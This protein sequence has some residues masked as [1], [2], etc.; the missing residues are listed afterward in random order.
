[1]VKIVVK[2]K[3]DG[4]ILTLSFVFIFLFLWI[5]MGFNLTNP[6][7]AYYEN[8]FTRAQDGI[9]YFAVESGFWY[10]IKL[11]VKFGIDYQLFLKIYS[12][13]G[14]LLISNS[15]LRYTKRPSLVLVAYFCYPFLLDVAQIRHF[16][17]VAIFTFAIRY[18]EKYSIK[19]LIRYCLLILIATSQQILAFSFFIYLLTYLTDTKK[20][21]K[22]A[23]FLTIINLIG[24]RYVLKMTF[25]QRIFSLRDK[26][27]NYTGGYSV[28][29]FIM[30]GCFYAGLLLIC[31]FLYKIN[32][33]NNLSMSS[34]N[35]FRDYKNNFIF[36]VCIYSAFFIPFIMLD[37]QYT[38]LFRGSIFIVYIFISNQLSL[39]KKEKKLIFTFAFLG[40]C[41]L[42]FIKL[43]VLSNDYFTTLTKPILEENS[44][45]ELFK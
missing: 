29:Q 36:K 7:Y 31:Y 23:V 10:L 34:D 2:H 17:A 19:N 24:F 22:F 38:R 9:T 43:F 16:M 27:I 39:L 6:D 41:L 11:V 44:L 4:R 30:Y 35:K 12:L 26:N 32:N 1:M 20:A 42:V 15:I 18:L 33:K 45:F 25:I 21:I 8:L 13:I 40:C 3:K 5:L 14:L 37:F 28:S